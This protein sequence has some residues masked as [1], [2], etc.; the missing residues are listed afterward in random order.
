MFPLLQLFG[1]RCGVQDVNTHVPC[2]VS[3]LSGNKYKQKSQNVCT[4][5]KEIPEPKIT[6][7]ESNEN[8]KNIF[9]VGRTY[10]KSEIVF[11]QNECNKIHENYDNVF[12]QILL[13]SFCVF[14]LG[15]SLDSFCVCFSLIFVAFV[16]C[17]FS[18]HVVIF[19]KSTRQ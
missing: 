2:F 5:T 8:Q 17:I 10:R 15:F 1:G 3:L 9:Y 14:L 13:R 19:Q 16:L 7:N 6:G 11:S 12:F 18:L 4:K